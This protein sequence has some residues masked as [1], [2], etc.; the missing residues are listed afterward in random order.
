MGTTAVPALANAHG[1]ANS[2]T[3]SSALQAT[4]VAAV[5]LSGPAG[6]LGS[7]GEAEDVAA[8][9]AGGCP[10]PPFAPPTAPA[11]APGTGCNGVARPEA[12]TACSPERGSAPVLGRDRGADPNPLPGREGTTGMPADTRVGAVPDQ[13]SGSVSC[14]LSSSPRSAIVPRSRRK[15]K[16]AAQ[17]A[18]AGALQAPTRAMCPPSGGGRSASRPHTA[19]GRTRTVA[20]PVHARQ[21]YAVVRRAIRRGRLSRRI[22]LL[23]LGVRRGARVRWRRR[24]CCERPPWPLFRGA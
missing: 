3:P 17:A 13:D 24:G 14:T 7:R 6:A 18:G 8:P 16:S 9:G 11:G 10:P 22:V 1:C 15:R 20:Q 2:V 23:A 19:W 21:S 12:P 4:V 5:T